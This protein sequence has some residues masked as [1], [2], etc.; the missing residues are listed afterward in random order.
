MQTVLS[1]MAFGAG[2]VCVGAAITVALILILAGRHTTVNRVEGWFAT[3]ISLS[4]F[5][6]GV[7]FFAVGIWS[8]I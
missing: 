2:A 7:G 6:V 5:I 3:L 8:A 4:I 1:Q